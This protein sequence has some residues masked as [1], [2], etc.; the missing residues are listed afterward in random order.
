MKYRRLT[1]IGV[2]ILVLLVIGVA[3]YFGSYA[4]G[5]NTRVKTPMEKE[6]EF[7]KNYEPSS[8]TLRTDEQIELMRECYKDAH[9]VVAKEAIWA[10]VYERSIGAVTAAFFEYRTK[11]R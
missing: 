2:L 6:I 9:L 1:I 7:W 5:E 8:Q 11:G 10:P 4:F 3:I